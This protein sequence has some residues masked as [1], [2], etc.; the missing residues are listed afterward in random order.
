MAPEPQLLLAPKIT[1]SVQ[2]TAGL[3][4]VK[5]LSARIL[6]SRT[7]VRLGHIPAAECLEDHDPTARPDGLAVMLSSKLP[8]Q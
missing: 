3:G 2:G 7:I 8:V 6:G 5:V 1:C 4:L